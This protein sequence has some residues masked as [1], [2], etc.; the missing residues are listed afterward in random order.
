[1]LDERETIGESERQLSNRIRSGLGDVVTG[2]RDGVEV[3]HSV[4]NKI[5]LNIP[6]HF[7]SEAGGEDTSVLRLILLQDVGL[8]RASHR[9]KRRRFDLLVS[10]AVYSLVA[11]NAEKTK[12]ERVVF[13]GQIGRVLG[14]ILVRVTLQDGVEFSCFSQMAFDLLIDRCIQEKGE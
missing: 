5:L 8:H 12:T 11:G 1:M 2:D 9:R 13:S 7:Q 3:P 14:K 4:R 6:H 10:L